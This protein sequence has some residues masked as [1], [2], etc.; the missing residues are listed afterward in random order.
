MRA[1]Y[2]SDS[3]HGCCLTG[4]VGTQ[5]TGDFA[6]LGFKAHAFEGF[7]SAITGNDVLDFQHS[8]LTLVRMT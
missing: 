7:N 3:E 5:Q 2:S 6:M 1:E 8:V 4:P